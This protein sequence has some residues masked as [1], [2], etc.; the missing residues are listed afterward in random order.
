MLPECVYP[1]RAALARA[2]G[3]SRAAV[4]LLITAVVAVLNSARVHRRAEVV[5]VDAIVCGVPVAVRVRTVHP[6]AV[7]VHTIAE[8]VHRVGI[9]VRVLRRAVVLVEAAVV[10]EVRVADSRA[11]DKHRQEQQGGR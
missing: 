11:G 5:A 9:D 10:I 4:T 7:L 1:T 3:I 6:V 8:G 2:E